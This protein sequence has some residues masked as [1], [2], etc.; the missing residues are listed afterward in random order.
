MILLNFSHP[1]TPEQLAQIE[2]LSECIEGVITLTLPVQ[3]D[4]DQSFLPQLE[5]LVDAIPLSAEEMQTQKILVNPPGLSSI[6]ALLLAE[7]HGRMGY[8][9]AIIRLRSIPESLPPRY[10]VAEILSLQAVRDAAGAADD[11]NEE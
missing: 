2:Q 10:E 1:I 6:T 7:L 4:Y 8:F 9:P 5:K 11:Q 3:F